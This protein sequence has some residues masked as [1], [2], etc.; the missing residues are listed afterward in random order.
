MNS[1]GILYSIREKASKAP[2]IG[3]VSAELHVNYW[4]LPIGRGKYNRFL[5]FGIMLNEV[6]HDI[7]SV[8]FY[9]PFSITKEDIEDLGEPL[10]KNEMLATLF[11]CECGVRN[12]P[13][14]LSYHTVT[15]FD[16]DRHRFWLYT[17]SQ[18][19]FSI[20]NLSGDKGCT[21][22]VKIK[23]IPNKTKGILANDDNQYKSNLYFRFR[24][25]NLSSKDFFHEENISNDF[26]Q[27]AFSKSELFDFRVNEMRDFD[28]GVYEELRN[29]NTFFSFNKVHFYFVGSSEDESVKGSK[30]YK[31]IRLLDLDRWNEYLGKNVINNKK[32]IAY[33]WC[34]KEDTF[35]KKIKI[36][37]QTIYKSLSIWRVIKYCSVIIGLN[38]LGCI[39]FQI[40]VELIKYIAAHE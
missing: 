1:V 11:N 6:A 7:E 17:L 27:G 25:N 3:N 4:K 8:L 14:N 36:P 34:Y 20:K 24:I 21:L 16:K 30:S 18:Q 28:K 35:I 23:S 5:D 9:F 40:L 10:T 15:P 13:S 22:S 33:H 29:G 26:L 32:I 12:N 37:L 2:R 38:I 39:I 19:N 31:D